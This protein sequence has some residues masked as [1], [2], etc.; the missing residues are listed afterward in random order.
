MAKAL[1][2]RALRSLGK[3]SLLFKSKAFYREAPCSIKNATLSAQSRRGIAL[4]LVLVQIAVLAIVV[5]ALGTMALKNLQST[6][7]KSWQRQARHAAYAGIQASLA[8]LDSDPNWSPSAAWSQ[9]LGHGGE[10]HYS[11]EVVNN[12]N[13]ADGDVVLAP[14]N[15]WVP[16]GTAWI[17]S[18]G[19]LGEVGTYQTSALIAL[20]SRARPVFDHAAFAQ[21]KIELSNASQVNSYRASVGRTP[22]SGLGADAARLAHLGTNSSAGGAIT[23]SGTSWTDGNAY[24]G[25]GSNPVGVVAINSG[26]QLTGGKLTLEE[27]KD[28]F[29]FHTSLN[30]TSGPAVSI[31]AFTPAGYS[32]PWETADM[33]GDQPR[34]AAYSSFEVRVNNPDWNVATNLFAGE[35]FVE[36]DLTFRSSGSFR[37]SLHPTVVNVH[38]NTEFPVIFYV[39]GNVLLDNVKINTVLPSS[40]PGSPSPRTLQ[41]YTLTDGK[42]FRMNNSE[43][44]AVVGGRG[45]SAE[46][47]NG[48]ELYG[49]V[50]A[51]RVALDSAKI[52]YD[53]DLRGITLNGRSAW[54]ILSMKEASVG[55]ADSAAGQLAGA[56]PRPPAL[57]DVALDPGLGTRR[58]GANPPA[59][60]GGT[61]D[62]IPQADL[63][64]PPPPPPP[65]T[66]A[67]CG[68]LVATCVCAEGP[69]ETPTCAD[70]G[71]D[72]AACIC[73]PI[74]KPQVRAGCPC[75]CGNGTAGCVLFD[76][77]HG[78]CAF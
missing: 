39:K 30:G 27:R 18:R 75:P 70:C 25:L 33:T 45:L 77:N 69:T 32:F 67:L 66:C 7:S 1:Y 5:A 53:S 29:R 55:E 12:V 28:V 51:G 61:R 60:P 37:S 59:S 74:H 38:A 36:G 34:Q 41:I 21:E 57:K 26:S 49:A 2:Q 54:D 14:D 22:Q 43:L 24:S 62:I 71:R 9:P 35:Y 58:G 19:Y 50:I 72:T 65:P 52:H 63:L 20:V 3:A 6:S 47:V 13:N 56:P 40:L 23:I 4:F 76:I 73:C 46:I 11:V 78:V 15:T 17:R 31:P 64:P 8:K 68:Q 10:L 42:T 44:H 48:S 16:P